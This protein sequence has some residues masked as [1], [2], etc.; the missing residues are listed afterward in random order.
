MEDKEL[1]EKTEKSI[2]KAAK[3]LTDIQTKYNIS[4]TDMSNLWNAFKEYC[5][6]MIKNIKD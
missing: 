6:I 5:K 1:F 2:Y 3:V 4:N